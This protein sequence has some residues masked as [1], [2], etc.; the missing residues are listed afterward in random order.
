[1]KYADKSC[2]TCG[3]TL[4]RE[5]TAVPLSYM[6]QRIYDEILKAGENGITSDDL[7]ARIY[8]GRMEPP[9]GKAAMFVQI[10]KANKILTP[11]GQRIKCG[12]GR[13]KVPYVIEY[14]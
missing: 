3:Q 2:P 14:L 5:G 4:P 9:S 12:V 7:Y 6:Q 11:T 13:R 8:L 10:H 1:M